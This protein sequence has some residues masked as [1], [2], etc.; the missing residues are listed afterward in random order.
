MI[1]QNEKSHQTGQKI[2][3]DMR[4]SYSPEEGSKWFHIAGFLE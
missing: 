3:D 1:I 2:G 4:G